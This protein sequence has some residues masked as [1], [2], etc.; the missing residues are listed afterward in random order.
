MGR[1]LSKKLSQLDDFL[2]SDA[3]TD[4]CM[5]LSELDGF[6]AGV[7]VCPE[8][9]KP[10][11]WMPKIWGGE[12]PVFDTMEQV[13]AING[14]IMW[15][16]N[17]IIRQLDQGQYAPIFDVDTRTDET[18]WEMWIEGFQ[19]ALILRPDACLT[20]GDGS[21]AH[22]AFST[23]M[24]LYDIASTPR[25]E[26]APMDVDVELERLAPDL[27]PF[28]LKELHRVRLARSGSAKQAVNQNFQK[29]GRNDPCPCGSGKKYKKCCLH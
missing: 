23:F 28:S 20:Y 3:V 14:T 7:I 19:K 17:D 16:Y 10:S 15:M 29:V 13:E 4:D 5:M 12:A 27:I 18:V 2:L 9:I 11:E 22:K 24:R 6:L 8:L 26:L 25:A 21:D 1:N